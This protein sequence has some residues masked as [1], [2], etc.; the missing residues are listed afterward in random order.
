MIS[1]QLVKL[2]PILEKE[3]LSDMGLCMVYGFSFGDYF[4]SS[5]PK[6]IL[7]LNQIE[8]VGA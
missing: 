1:F 8:D 2:C 6:T 3:L 5:K 7:K 4:D